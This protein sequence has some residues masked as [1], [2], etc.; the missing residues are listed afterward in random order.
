LEIDDNVFYSPNFNV[1][2]AVFLHPK[3]QRGG[4]N[5]TKNFFSGKNGPNLSLY[6]VF[7]FEIAI[8]KQ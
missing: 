6:E 4:A 5:D 8:F 7:C 1:A 2:Q 3:I